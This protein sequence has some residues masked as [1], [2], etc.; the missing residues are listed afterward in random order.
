MM[1]GCWVHLVFNMLCTSA[2][3]RFLTHP[4][5]QRRDQILLE[6]HDDESWGLKGWILFDLNLEEPKQDGYKETRE[7]GAHVVMDFSKIAVVV[8]ARV[9]NFS[10]ERTT[11]GWASERGCMHSTFFK[12]SGM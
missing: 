5:Y 11:S 12:V 1:D 3:V 6:K 4:L 7:D 9:N 10:I 8:T 2:Y